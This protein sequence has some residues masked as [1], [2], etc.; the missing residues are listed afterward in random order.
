MTYSYIISNL[1]YSIIPCFIGSTN[2]LECR[3]ANTPLKK[4]LET[5]YSND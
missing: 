3:Y 2:K 5:N 4:F 1:V